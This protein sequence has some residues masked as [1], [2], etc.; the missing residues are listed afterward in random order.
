MRFGKADS[1]ILQM[2]M[3]LDS[4]EALAGYAQ[5]LLTAALRFKLDGLVILCEDFLIDSANHVNAA[6]M[7]IFAKSTVAPRLEY[8]CLAVMALNLAEARMSPGYTSLDAD[9][10]RR[11]L[12]L[13]NLSADDIITQLREEL[14][15][16][17][18]Q[19]PQ[20]ERGIS[21]EEIDIQDA[22]ASTQLE[23]DACVKEQT[24]HQQQ[25]EQDSV[26]GSKTHPGKEGTPE[27]D[28]LQ[29]P[30]T[31]HKVIVQLG[32]DLTSH[33]VQAG[34]SPDITGEI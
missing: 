31:D 27:H 13:A 15:A 12:G 23:A 29:T 9:C 20:K 30:H 17:V 21:A 16:I 25:E 28:Q 19:S 1:S 14:A 8:A 18:N 2:I 24:K 5:P 3:S 11:L 7:L 26:L 4:I 33:P 22:E 10:C 34:P 6:E 32:Q